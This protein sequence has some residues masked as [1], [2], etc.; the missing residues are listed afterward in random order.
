MPG[1]NSTRSGSGSRVEDCLISLHEI[2]AEKL[3]DVNS[4]SK[5]GTSDRANGMVQGKL[6]VPTIRQPSSRPGDKSA[7]DRP[8]RF[9]L[10]STMER[11]RAPRQGGIAG[12][13]S[14]FRESALGRQSMI[15]DPASGHGSA[16]GILLRLR[17]RDQPNMPSPAS[18]PASRIRAGKSGTTTLRGPSSQITPSRFRAD[19]CLLT[20]SMVR[21]R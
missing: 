21:P 16:V 3:I 18:L 17:C 9:R 5:T 1:S 7:R 19:I 11:D 2:S 8:E 20:V 13:R 4:D 10:P 6:H 14:R 12:I 15:E